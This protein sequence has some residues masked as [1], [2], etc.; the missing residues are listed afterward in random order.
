MSN[1]YP[2]PL[3]AFMECG[4]KHFP[5]CG[6]DERYETYVKY[7]MEQVTID[8]LWL[9]MGVATGATAEKIINMMPAEKVLYGFDWFR[10]LPEAW[11][12]SSSNIKHEGEMFGGGYR[13]IPEIER[14]EIVDGLFEETLPVFVEETEGNVAFLH[15]DCDLYSSTKTI[16]K[17]LKNK[18]KSGTIIMFDELYNY[19]NYHL[20]EYKAFMEYVT[21]DNIDFEWVAYL[22]GSTGDKAACRIL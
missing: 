8:G 22:G 19:S 12:I 20:H 17:Y 2:N 1:K 18:L 13:E 15:V 6:F 11:V 21:E 5:E 7:C 10:G 16:F 3:D 9:E 4:A 14:L